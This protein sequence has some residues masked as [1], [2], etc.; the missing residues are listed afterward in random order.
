MWA[1]HA[2]M[3]ICAGCLY[4]PC[5]GGA[6]WSHT[7]WGTLVDR[8]FTR[9][10]IF[11]LGFV[12]PQTSKGKGLFFAL[13]NSFRVWLWSVWGKS[14]TGT[15]VMLDW[16]FT[17]F[18]L[19]PQELIGWGWGIVSFW[20][21]EIFWVCVWWWTGSSTWFANGGHEEWRSCWHS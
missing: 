3:Y 19:S 8:P 9:L 11:Q 2:C 17:G 7:Y 13:F 16:C 10:M 6:I 5:F 20:N 21:G 15:A 1:M 12:I 18:A 14:C 4:Q